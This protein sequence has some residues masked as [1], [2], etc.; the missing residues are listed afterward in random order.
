MQSELKILFLDDHPGVRDGAGTLLS[1]RNKNFNFFY[2]RNCKEG[3]TILKA[4]PDIS[5]SIIDLNIDGEDGITSLTSF[6]KIQ[7][8]LKAIIYSMYCAPKNVE[9][10][11]QTGVDGYVTKNTE[12]KELEN[13]IITVTSGGKYFSSEPMKMMQKLLFKTANLEDDCYKKYKSLTPT[14]QEVFSLLAEKKEPY[15]IA[16]LLGKKLK[17]VMNQRS[18]IYQKLGFADRL[19]LI[20]FA[21]AIGVI[22]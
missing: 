22:F 3:E 15:E 7:P 16:E 17:T 2:A 21:K 4:N 14:E 13:A 10:A 8:T 12:I 18:I 19:D 1:Q 9:N 5:L 6:R 20:E 11:V